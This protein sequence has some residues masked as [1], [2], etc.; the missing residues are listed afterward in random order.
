MMGRRGLWGQVLR[1]AVQIGALAFVLYAALGGPWRNFKVAHNS[2][3]LVTLMEGPAVG[4]AYAL[5]E[6][7]LSSWDEPYE[8]SLDFLGMFGSST[9]FGLEGADPVLVASHAVRTGTADP[10]LLL[11][12]VIPVLL[13]LLLGKVFCSHL[14]PM[15][16]LFELGQL[17]RGGLLRLGVPLPHLRHPQRFGGWILLGGLVAAALTGGA[18]WFLVLPYLSVAAGLFLLVTAGTTAGLFVV[19][20]GWL[21]VDVLAAPGLFCRNVCPQGW[22][23]EQL[24]RLSL[25]K[26][27]KRG[28]EPCP[29]AC[30]TCEITCPYG[31]SP[32]TMTHTPACDACG[33]CVTTCPKGRLVRRL[34]A[35]LALLLLLLVPA[36]PAE[37]HHNKG[38]PHYGYYENYPQVPTNDHVMVEGDWEM[39]ATIFNFQGYDAR[40]S[41]DTP[42]DVKFYVYLYDLEADENYT[43]P[44]DFEIRLDGEVVSAFSRETVDEELV[45]ST[46]ETLPETGDYELVADLPDGSGTL[47]LP[48]HVDL[49]EGGVDWLLLGGLGFPVA[50]VFLLALLGKGRKGRAERLEAQAA[51]V[52][53]LVLGAVL[54]STTGLSG[55]AQAQ[56]PEP[57]N[58][59][60]ALLGDYCGPEDA[61]YYTKTDGDVVMVMDGIPGWLLVLGAALVIVTS[62]LVL[63]RWG[64]RKPSGWRLNLLRNRRVYR[65]VRSRWFQAVPQLLMV[66]VLVFLIWA[67]LT[68]SRYRNITPVAVWTVW[69]A[70]LIFTVALFGSAFCFACPWDGLANL[71]SRLRV[72][73]RV[74]PLSLGLRVP[75]WMRNLYPAIFLFALLS[76]AEL[77]MGVTSDPRMTAYMGL[78][79]AV[80]AVVLALAFDGKA[81]CKHV[82]PVGRINGIYA[83]F[84]PVEVRP[85]KPAACRTCE[86]EDCRT[87]NEDGYP[88]PTGITLKHAVDATYCT[89]CMEC[90]KSC[91]RQNVALNLRP[92]GGDLPRMRKARTDEAWLA[93]S[94][95][96]LTLFHG[97]SMTTAWESFAPGSTSILKWM[98]V[99]LGTPHTW[100]F[101]VAMAV[102][103]AI[104]VALYW[105]SCKLAARWTQG[106]GVS[107][108]R[109]FV[110]YAWSLLPVALFY[111]LAHNAMH[112]FSE[113]GEIVP[114]LSDPLG[115]GDDWLGTAGVSVGHLLSEPTIW[116]LQV[117][118][119]VVGHVFGVVV[120]HRVSRRLFRDPGHAT[121]SLIPM[122]AVMILIS[123]AGLTLMVADMNMRVGRM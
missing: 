77:G 11:G 107:A 114:M 95:L 58:R 66:G 45:Y 48:F 17:V 47:S 42:R 22:L 74:E 101:T 15:R 123:V 29:D 92:F 40:Q 62:F 25:L 18:F 97:L 90:V 115:R 94:L 111:H 106:S 96:A 68:G 56:D 121:R 49:N 104:P 50:L 65:V 80:G 32:K 35:P 28:L 103:C 1:K 71:M 78:G 31:L 3:R 72:K 5:N 83:N 120:A 12:L 13:A 85:K 112:L 19:A 79:M 73:A 6:R 23:L 59:D 57:A 82:C 67:G 108:E 54:L 16:L 102:A 52:K 118:L 51:A 64:S 89:L 87:G 9:V 34:G 55:A 63:E 43:G 7:V 105:G 76:W 98:S 37:A 10:T 61:T 33:L 36:S 60:L 20:G 86:T 84:A 88:C 30:R 24:G 46:R 116:G 2:E 109:M 117:A 91:R 93:L 44:V 69:W 39:G 99:T 53:G 75:D 100:N 4:D 38:L 122:T 26:L 41:S 113:G 119:I 110:Q 21:L 81:F 14:C 8:A 70:G 27:R